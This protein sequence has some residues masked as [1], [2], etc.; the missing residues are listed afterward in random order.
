MITPLASVGPRM[1]MTRARVSRTLAVGSK[2]VPED[3]SVPR[4]K[5][6]SCVSLILDGRL[7]LFRRRSLLVLS[8]RSR[9]RLEWFAITH[10][11]AASRR[12]VLIAIAW[13]ARLSHV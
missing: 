6:T 13:S 9:P 5:G 2:V 8:F 7:F 3:V 1:P 4:L 10:L 12:N 11:V